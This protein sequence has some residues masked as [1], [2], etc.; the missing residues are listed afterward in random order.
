MLVKTHLVITLFFVLLLLSFVNDKLLFAV[1]ALAA[2]LIPDIDTSH[3]KLGKRKIFRFLQFFVKH[4]GI[5]HSFTFLFVISILIYLFNPILVFPLVLGYGLHLLA[6]A[7]TVEGIM[8]FHPLKLVF[9]GKIRV[10]KKA[11]LFVF[12][13]FSF[14]DLLILSKMI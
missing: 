10:G 13:L 7:F 8:P 6:D 5:V 14:A 4:R 1:V 3:S 12:L 11:E 2:T 9:S